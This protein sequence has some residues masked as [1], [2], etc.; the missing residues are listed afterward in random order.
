MGG[1]SYTVWQVKFPIAVRT[2]LAARVVAVGGRHKMT[3]QM[4]SHEEEH[5]QGIASPPPSSE[6]SLLTTNRPGSTASSLRSLP[7][8]HA[9]TSMLQDRCSDT[10]W[11]KS[12]ERPPSLRAMA[13]QDVG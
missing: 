13:L 6:N 8:A 12:S 1:F 7:L 5:Q 3:S 11:G 4:T 10:T 9:S 2:V